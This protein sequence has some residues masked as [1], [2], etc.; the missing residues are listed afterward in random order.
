M[1]IRDRYTRWLVL[2]SVAGMVC[3]LVQ[4]FEG[5]Y[6]TKGAIVA[7]ALFTCFWST[8]FLEAWKREQITLAHRW[9]TMGIEDVETV[10]PEF[11]E[12]AEA[13]K[14]PYTAEPCLLYTSPSPRDR[15]RSR[16]PSSA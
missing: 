8:L 14:N 10:R 11:I 7:Y 2:P 15:T 13:K 12:V 4:I 1:C 6:D 3:F 16:M 9:G 5:S